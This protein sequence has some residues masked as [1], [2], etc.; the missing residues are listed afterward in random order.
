[1]VVVWAYSEMESSIMVENCN[2]DKDPAG[3]EEN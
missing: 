2:F 3:E 1:M